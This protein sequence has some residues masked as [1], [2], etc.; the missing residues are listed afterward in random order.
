[1]ILKSTSIF[2][3]LLGLIQT[4]GVCLFLI[5]VIKPIYEPGTDLNDYAI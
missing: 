5:L 2:Y 4:V 1:M 3:L